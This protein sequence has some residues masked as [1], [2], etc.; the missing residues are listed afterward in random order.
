MNIIQLE[1]RIKLDNIPL[2]AYSLTGG[3]PN[4][5]YCIC[6]MNG[7]WEVYYSERGNKTKLKIFSSEE[8]ACEYFYH[9]IIS[10]FKK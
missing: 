7:V 4:E 1:A 5:A 9:W 8:A 10:V 2:D 6:N 3:Y